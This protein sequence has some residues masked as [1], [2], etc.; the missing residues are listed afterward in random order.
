MHKTMVRHGDTACMSEAGW[1]DAR[2]IAKFCG[3]CLMWCC[4][5]ALV[6]VC[7]LLVT[8]VIGTA[9]AAAKDDGIS[10]QTAT[11]P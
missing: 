9:D 11:P 8:I 6:I 2:L 4:V 7:V 3:Y 5:Y 10:N 1:G